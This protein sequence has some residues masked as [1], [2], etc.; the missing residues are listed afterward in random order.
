MSDTPPEPPASLPDLEE[1]EGIIPLIDL[2]YSKVRADP[3]V[4]P[5]FADIAA[6]DWEKHLPT[7]VGFWQSVLFSGES[8]VETYRGNLIGAHAALLSK[9][10]MEWPRFE[11]WLALF[12]EAVDT[13]YAGPRAEHI[14]RCADD[15]ANV[16]YSRINGVQDRRFA[17]RFPPPPTP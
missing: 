12:T 6:V 2:F 11:R 16:L 1:K 7:M 13:L 14:K 8:G 4:G 5:V 10:S 9:T 3:L 17:G 15:M